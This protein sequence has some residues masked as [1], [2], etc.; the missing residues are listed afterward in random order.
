M[1][2]AVFFDFYYTLVHYEPPQQELEARAL[3]D[4]G[5]NASPDVFTRPL[6]E[7]NEFLY[8]E[9]ARCPLS[10]RSKE[11]TMALYA[12]YQRIL[13]NGA[14]I[15]AD[16]ELILALLGKIQKARMKLALFDD[17]APALTELKK[18]RLILGLISNVDYDIASTLSGLGLQSWLDI[19]VTSLESGFSKPQ[20]EIFREGI[21][22]GGVQ[23][24]E[25]IYVGD[26]Y[27]VDCVAASRAG[28][29]AI[30]IDR[31]GYFGE[32]S[33][34]LRIGSLTGVAGYL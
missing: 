20:P 1:I 16:E 29:K 32:I 31:A 15:E 18:R 7:A 9:A 21:R 14:G 2:K 28:M 23:A 22:R 13:L 24:S 12:Q 6:L 26:Q 3:R 4:F 17:V 19:I 27:K 11:E 34:C 25:A 30:L 33:D 5:I 10:R 8:G